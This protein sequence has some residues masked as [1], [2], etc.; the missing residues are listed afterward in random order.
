[1]AA[2]ARARAAGARRGSKPGLAE[3]ERRASERDGRGEAARRGPT[4]RGGHSRGGALHEASPLGRHLPRGEDDDIE[5]RG[6]DQR[7]ED[8]LLTEAARGGDDRSSL[9]TR[10]GSWSGERSRRGRRHRRGVRAGGVRVARART[11]IAQFRFRLRSSRRS[12]YVSSSPSSFA[13]RDG[14]RMGACGRGGGREAQVRDRA[15]ED[16]LSARAS[17]RSQQQEQQGSRIQSAKSLVFLLCFSSQDKMKVF[18]F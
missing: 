17:G 7:R 4:T 6:E 13:R 5:H 14:P 11:W 18:F 16:F 8:V 3:D 1:M 2:R 10:V 9:L 15:G 12:K